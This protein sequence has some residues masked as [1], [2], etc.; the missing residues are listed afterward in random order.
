M[1]GD[2]RG[3]TVRVWLD[4]LGLLVGGEGVEG[5]TQEQTY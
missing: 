5:G 4:Q 2:C 3:L 1:T